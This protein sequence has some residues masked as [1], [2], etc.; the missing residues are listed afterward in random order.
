MKVQDIL[1]KIK[2]NFYKIRIFLD[3]MCL[4]IRKPVVRTD[5]HLGIFSR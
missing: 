2:V 1:Y 4:N 5:P 3:R